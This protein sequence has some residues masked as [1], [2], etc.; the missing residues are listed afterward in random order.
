MR[1]LI[2]AGI[3][4]LMVAA[5]ACTPAATPT[6]LISGSPFP[7]PTPTPPRALTPTAS[8][9]GPGERV[10]VMPSVNHVPNGATVTYNSIPPT[11]GSHYAQPA[12]DG[13]F[14]PETVLADET[15]VHNL[16]HS[17]VVIS[18]NFK[19]AKLVDQLRKVLTDRANYPCYVVARYYTK[20]PEGSI[21]LSAW[22]RKDGPFFPTSDGITPLVVERINAFLDAY[23]GHNGIAPEWFPCTSSMPAAQRTPTRGAVATATPTPA[24]ANTH[25]HIAQFAFSPLPVKAPANTAVQFTVVNGDTTSHTF[26]IADLGIDRE[27]AGN[28]SFNSDP[29][30]YK[31]GRYTLVCRIHPSMQAQVIIGNPPVAS[32]LNPTPTTFDPYA[33]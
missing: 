16:E 30:L 13:F 25:V 17:E 24:V 19:D 6:P 29:K 15:I 31:E 4:G 18:Y 20:I 2:A 10:A 12:Q 5:M 23:A 26:T 9:S 28:T 33:Y 14:P 21:A 11:S 22:T 8:L 7:T 1:R 3:A 32:N 27:L